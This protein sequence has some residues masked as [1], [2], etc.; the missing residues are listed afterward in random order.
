MG[1]LDE[2]SIEAER[3]EAKL[4]R[5]FALALDLLCVV[6]AE[7]RLVQVNQAWTT[8][9]GHPVDELTGRRFID[10]VH[11]D[12]V[13]ASLAAFAELRDRPVLNFVN[14]YRHRDGS[15]RTLE[16]WAAPF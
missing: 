14:R 10:L 16:W 9:L 5:L 1:S 13:A 7:G 6:D 11:P 15:Y 8:T 3:N 2:A 4:D 12:D